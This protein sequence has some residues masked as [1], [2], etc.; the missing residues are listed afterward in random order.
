MVSTLTLEW[1]FAVVARVVSEVSTLAATAWRLPDLLHPALGIAD[2]A[3]TYLGFRHLCSPSGLVKLTRILA[4]APIP[5][6]RRSESDRFSSLLPVGTS[7]GS[8][9][10]NE[11]AEA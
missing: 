3:Q 2:L 7:A 6:P 1:F 11:L 4:H 9:G 5:L 10:R 8:A